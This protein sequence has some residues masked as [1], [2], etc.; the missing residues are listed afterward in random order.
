MTAEPL[1]DGVSLSGV[2]PKVGVIKEGGR[3]VGRTKMQDTHIIASCLSSAN[4]FFLSSSMCRCA[5]R[6]PRACV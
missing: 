1:D 2:Q 6:L 3:Y 5:W 4:L